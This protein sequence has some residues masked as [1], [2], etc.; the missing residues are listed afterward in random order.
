MMRRGSVSRW[1][2]RQVIAN[3]MTSPN[4]TVVRQLVSL[5]SHFYFV[6]RMSISFPGDF[7]RLRSVI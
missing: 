4:L 1:K 2:R 3:C 7:E 6:F 5:T